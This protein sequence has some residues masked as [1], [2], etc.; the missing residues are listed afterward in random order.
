MSPKKLPARAADLAYATGRRR[1]A[2][3]Y[4][5][6]A[7]LLEAEDGLINVCV[8]LCVLA[9]IAAGDAINAAATGTRYSGQ[10]HLAAADMLKRVDADAGSRL[11]ALVRLKP[12][13]H[14][15]SALLGAGERT[16]A[17]RNAAHLVA[18]AARRT[19]KA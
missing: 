7:E 10:D 6:A 8:G 1:V 16:T 5:E 2:E 12:A 9:G 15:G 11:R 14:Y 18:D 3:Q 19:E 4:L 13:A 17:L